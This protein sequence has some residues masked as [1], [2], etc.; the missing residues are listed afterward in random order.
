[1]NKAHPIC[2]L[3]SS[4]KGGLAMGCAF[5]NGQVIYFRITMGVV[6]VYAGS[7]LT[8]MLPPTCHQYCMFIDF[9]CYQVVLIERV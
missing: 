6:D 9:V 7:D 3:S 2:W 1:M 8:Y 5:K 4:I